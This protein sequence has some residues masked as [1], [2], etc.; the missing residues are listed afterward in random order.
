MCVNFPGVLHARLCQLESA[1]AP[2]VL[3]ILEARVCLLPVVLVHM[4]CRF[5]WTFFPSFS[6]FLV[7]CPHPGVFH[8]LSVVD[9]LL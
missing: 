1:F 2:L 4:A 7:S 6:A 5:C 9:V 3:G 8:Q